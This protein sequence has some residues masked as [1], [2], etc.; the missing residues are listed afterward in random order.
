MLHFAVTF[1][2]FKNLKIK[3]NYRVYGGRNNREIN[4]C[5]GLFY[6]RVKFSD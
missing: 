4:F 2:L 6:I 5:G 1:K 3:C